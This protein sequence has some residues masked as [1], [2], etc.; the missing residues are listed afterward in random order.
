MAQNKNALLRYRT[1]DR[2]LRNTGRR[3]TLQDL[4]DACSDALYEYEGKEDPVSTRTVQLDLQMMRSDRLGYEAPIEVYDKKYYRYADPNYSISNRPLSQHD[5]DV[6]NRTIDLLRQF[7]EFDSFH[8]MADVV[9][10]LQDKVASA[11]K[12]RPIVDFERNPNLKGLEH[13]NAFYDIIASQQTVCVNYR[14]FNSRRPVPFFLFPYLLKEYRNRWFLFGSRAGDM[15]LFNLALDRIVD[16]HA[17]P[18]IPFKENPEFGEDFFDDVIGVTKHSR[19]KK[20]HIVLRVENS[21]SG[22][23]LTKPIHSSQQLIEKNKSDGSMTFSL[24]VI[25][26]QELIAQLLTFGPDIR[27]LEPQSLANHL[28][29]IHRQALLP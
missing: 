12:R 15:K 20:E 17:C 8:D 25:V 29:D 28:R 9:S 6:L 24:D 11:S 4:V 1:I 16:F 18:D 23:I 3:W 26:N 5:I 19:L 2:C 14:S 13:L 10:R 7:D 22:Y 27:I 21:Q